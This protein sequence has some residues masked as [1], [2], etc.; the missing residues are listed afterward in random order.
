MRILYNT[1]GYR[2]Y[3]DHR[4]NMWHHHRVR[5]THHHNKWNGRGASASGDDN[6]HFVGHWWM[7]PDIKSDYYWEMNAQ[8]YRRPTRWNM[9]IE[10]NSVENS[11][12]FMTHWHEIIN[13]RHTHTQRL[14]LMCMLDDTSS[15]VP[16]F[17]SLSL[18]FLCWSISGD[19]RII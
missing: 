15:L 9:K 16:V 13:R 7:M 2:Q 1:T 19:W 11:L 14:Q 8:A 18:F 12:I 5:S 3:T 17:S 10:I 4:H 6:F